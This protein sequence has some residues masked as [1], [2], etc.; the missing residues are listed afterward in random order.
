MRVKM[1]RVEVEWQQDESVCRCLS[2]SVGGAVT[3]TLF[4]H[5]ARDF[6]VF[7]VVMRCKVE[8]GTFPEYRWFLN[9]SRLEGRG[10][11]YALGGA[12]NSSLSLSVGR[13]S[14]GVYQ[15]QASDTF[16]KTTTIRSLKILIN[17]DGT[18][19]QSESNTEMFQKCLFT[20]W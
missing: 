12:H 8:R 4:K 15:C 5:V 9:D 17:R 2:E 13:H 14:S 3:V 19:S 7:G 16:D 1:S 20:S 11:F 6:Q 18:Q 10:S